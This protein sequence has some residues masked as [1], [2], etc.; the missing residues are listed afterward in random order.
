MTATGRRHVFGYVDQVGWITRNLGAAAAVVYLTIRAHANQE[1][2]SCFPEQATIAGEAGVDERTVRRAIERLRLP[3]VGALSVQHCYG[4]KGCRTSDDYTLDRDWRPPARDL[5]RGELER[6]VKAAPGKE[7]VKEVDLPHR[8]AGRLPDKSPARLPDKSPASPA[9]KSPAS[10]YIEVNNTNTLTTPVLST[11]ERENGRRIPPGRSADPLPSP[12]HKLE[13]A[14]AH[15]NG[16]RQPDG[17]ADMVEAVTFV[18]YYQADD[19]AVKRAAYGLVKAGADPDMVADERIMRPR[20]MKDA[21]LR[22][23]QLIARWREAKAEQRAILV[24]DGLALIRGDGRSVTLQPTDDGEIEVNEHHGGWTLTGGE[25]ELL[26]EAEVRELAERANEPRWRVDML[27][28]WAAEQ[29]QAATI[30]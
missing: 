2:K 29:R 16:N 12:A 9:D 23:H 6:A 8:P 18:T 4:R 22:P 20:W 17:L 1:G 28:D 3:I 26:S 24:K 27:L 19:P 25:H 30:A 7:A 13:A 5:E 21:P 15:G 10:L 11:E 14:P